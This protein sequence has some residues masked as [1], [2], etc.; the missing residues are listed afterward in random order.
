ML[1]SDFFGNLRGN[2]LGWVG[3]FRDFEDFFN[4]SQLLPDMEGD[5]WEVIMSQPGNENRQ[6][7]NS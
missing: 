3:V 1:A 2:L 7:L 6:V 5:R 4:Q